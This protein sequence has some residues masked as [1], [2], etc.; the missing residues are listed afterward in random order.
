LNDVLPGESRGIEYRAK[1]GDGCD[2]D[3]KY[4]N[5]VTA[6]GVNDSEEPVVG[7]DQVWVRWLCCENKAP[8]APTILGETLLNIEDKGSFSAVTTDPDNDDIYYL[9]DW[10]DGTDSGWIGSFDS[11][12]ICTYDHYWI[13]SDIYEI[14]VKAKDKNGAES[15]FSPV[16]KVQINCPPDNP[17]NPKPEPDKKDVNVNTEFSWTGSD[18]DSQII[19]YDVFFGTTISPPKVVSNQSGTTFNPGKLQDGK[20]YYWKIIAWDE[21]G[22][23]SEG[24]QWSFTTLI[25]DESPVIEIL[26]PKKGLYISN[27]KIRPY[28]IHKPLIIGKI[29]ISVIAIDYISG[30]ER[31]EF[32]IDNVLISTDYNEPYTWTWQRE[33]FIKLYKLDIVVYDYSGN[34]ATNSMKVWKLF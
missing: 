10:G 22:A 16:L 3:V 19:K 27:I 2:C 17:D 23:S 5:D 25:D 8:V 12:S 34:E 30:V 9:F 31:V 26:K 32:Y 18:P 7:T 6:T 20:T 33:K 14:K 24:L 21:Q 1:I 29:D 13:E 15:S 11:G 4:W 28:L